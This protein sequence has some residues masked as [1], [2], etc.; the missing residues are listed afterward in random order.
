[1]TSIYIYSVY[2]CIFLNILISIDSYSLPIN[3]NI[4]IDINHIYTL[5][6][7]YIYINYIY[8]HKLIGRGICR[9]KTNHRRLRLGASVSTLGTGT[10]LPATELELK[11]QL[12]AAQATIDALKAQQEK[13]QKEQGLAADE[14]ATRNA[15]YRRMDAS[16]WEK[17]LLQE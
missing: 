17:H 5:I 6:R 9:N 16:L 12:A 7:I 8:T 1:M 15:L 3:I 14:M 10:T 4:Y 2:L 11:A 13:L